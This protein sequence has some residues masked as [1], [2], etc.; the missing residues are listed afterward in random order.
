VETASDVPSESPLYQFDQVFFARDT[1]DAGQTIYRVEPQPPSEEIDE[2]PAG[3]PSFVAD[4]ETFYYV[5]FN[6]YVEYD[7]GGETG[8]VN[9]EPDIGAQVDKLPEGTT[10]VEEDGATYHQFDM[11]FFEDVQDE[12]GQSFYEVVDSPDGAD[13]VELET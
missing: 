6:L 5:N 11:V 1:N 12:N 9:G 3:S 13:V 7:E 10:T 8:Y 4:G 2:I